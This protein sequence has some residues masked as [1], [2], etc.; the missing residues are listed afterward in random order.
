[1]IKTASGF[2]VGKL[3]ILF[4]LFCIITECCRNKKRGNAGDFVYGLGATNDCQPGNS[5]ARRSRAE[6]AA[7]IARSASSVGGVSDGAGD[8]GLEFRVQCFEF[9][10]RGTSFEFRV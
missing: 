8:A 9:R 3:I 7:E 5:A 10:V 4:C 6:Q 1:M 2:F